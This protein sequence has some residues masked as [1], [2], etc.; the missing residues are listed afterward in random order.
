VPV[1]DASDGAAAVGVE[2]NRAYGRYREAGVGL[3]GG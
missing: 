3:V 1:Q 2:L